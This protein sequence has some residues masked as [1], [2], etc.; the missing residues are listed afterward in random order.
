MSESEGKGIEH[1]GPDEYRWTVACTP[2]LVFNERAGT[3]MAQCA[4]CG[5]RTAEYPRRVRG[6]PAR[7]GRGDGSLDNGLVEITA[8]ERDRAGWVDPLVLIEW[9]QRHIDSTIAVMRE[10]YEH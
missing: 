8:E 3:I 7:A 2:S 10:L 5:S 6:M 4:S 1:R 9:E